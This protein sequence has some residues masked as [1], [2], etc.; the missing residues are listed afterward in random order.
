MSLFVQN[1][2]IPRLTSTCQ[3]SVIVITPPTCNRKSQAAKYLQILV[4]GNPDL[5]HKGLDK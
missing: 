3:Y 4:A 5:S 1:D 2:N